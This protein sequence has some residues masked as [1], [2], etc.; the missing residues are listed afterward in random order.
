MELPDDLVAAKQ[1]KSLQY[2]KLVQNILDI[3]HLDEEETEQLKEL[4]KEL[5]IN[6]KKAYPP[7]LD[8]LLDTLLS[9][10]FE[11][12]TIC[13]EVA[14]L[15][16]VVLPLESELTNRI[17]AFLKGK[18]RYGSTLNSQ[19][20]RE[21]RA[22]IHRNQIEKEQF[23]LEVHLSAAQLDAYRTHPIKYNSTSNIAIASYQC[24]TTAKILHKIAI[25]QHKKRHAEEYILEWFASQ[26]I[27]TKNIIE[28]YSEIE[29]CNKTGHF[30]KQ[31]LKQ[32]SP[33]AHITYSFD[34]PNEVISN[35]QTT[36][37]NIPPF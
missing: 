9:T 32:Q 34:Y 6:Q 35:H 25:S 19:H 3:K 1:K 20:L 33:Q 4:H 29:P 12:Y 10:T 24:P 27:D 8:T 18:V 2:V 5:C 13:K 14:T 30:C 17:L 37:C 26:Q 7:N 16:L 21:F 23:S 31:K 36:I 11:R 22:K 28:W 15:L